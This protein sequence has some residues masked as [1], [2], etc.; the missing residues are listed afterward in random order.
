[1]V[2]NDI[3]IDPFGSYF[4][5]RFICRCNTMLNLCRLFWQKKSTCICHLHLGFIIFLFRFQFFAV[6]ATVFATNIYHM[7]LL[8]FFYGLV[9]GLSLP[10][11]VILITEVTPLYY[12]GR[13]ITFL[14]IMYI[15]G[16]L[17]IILLA[18]I[19]MVI[20]INIF[21]LNRIVYQKEIG[22]RLQPWIRY[23]V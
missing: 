3:S 8:R 9:M 19:F 18:G 7:Y 12:R 6:L 10:I 4:Q 1:M 5:Y 14:Q 13:L 20:I 21:H 17:W 23:H 11:S 2:I 16:H 22:E 15:L